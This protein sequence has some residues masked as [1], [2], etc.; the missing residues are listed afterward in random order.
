MQ[1]VNK[2]T[3]TDLLAPLLAHASGC[4]SCQSEYTYEVEVVCVVC[5]RPLCSFCAIRSRE[6]QC[7]DCGAAPRV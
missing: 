2:A 6:Y 7:P 1:D 4:R 3:V 5:G